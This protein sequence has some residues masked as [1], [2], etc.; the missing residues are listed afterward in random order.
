MKRI[1]IEF[2]QTEVEYLVQVLLVAAVLGVLRGGE[3]RE[4]AVRAEHEQQRL[5]DPRTVGPA[6]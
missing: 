6:R 3:V 4:H 1:D 2:A 5:I